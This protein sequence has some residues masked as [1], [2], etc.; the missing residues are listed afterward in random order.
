MTPE[1]A[2]H[3]PAY[4]AVGRILHA[5]P[6]CV[7]VVHALFLFHRPF[8]LLPVSLPS[9]QELSLHGSLGA[10]SGVDEEIQ[11]ASLNH[12]NI[13]TCYSPL[14]I[15]GTWRNSLQTSGTCTSL[16][17][18]IIP[19][20]SMNSRISWKTQQYP[21]PPIWPDYAVVLQRNPCLWLGMFSTLS[22]EDTE[23]AWLDSCAGLQWW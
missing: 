1:Y 14:H 18:N 7:R 9:L 12:L 17:W 22:I 20:L 5:I 6:H 10:A 11:F 15:F 16:L 2:R 8:S 21:Y 13:F 19:I 3:E 23:A 4:G